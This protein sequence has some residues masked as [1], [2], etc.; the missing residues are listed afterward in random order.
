MKLTATIT[1]LALVGCAMTAVAQ[2]AAAATV[3]TSATY[4]LVSRYSGKAVQV[5]STADGE[6]VVQATRVDS[7]AQQWQFVDSGGGYYRLKSRLSGKVVDIAS[8]STA[9]G[10]NVVQWTDKNATN[11]Q[12]SLAD[13]DGGYVRFVNRNSGKALDLWERSTADGAR[14]SQYDDNG[15]TNQQWQLV[16]LAAATVGAPTDPN[17]RYFGRW[18]YSNPAAYVSEWAGAY[19]VVGFTGRTIKLRQRNAI[20]FY[21]SIDGGADV[22]YTNR[23]GTVDLTP[24]PL[25]SGNHTMRVS[26]RPIAG[27]YRGDAVFQ[28][29]QLDAGA[30]TFAPTVPSRIVEF[31]GDSITVGQL[32]SKQALTAYGWLASERLGLGHTQIAVGGACLVSAAD[33]C[34]GMSD[35]F[36]RTGLQANASNWDFSRY[37]ADVVVINLGTNDVGHSVTGA[38]FQT[39]YVTLLRRA[40]EKYPNATV[41]ALQTFRKRFIPE[42]QAA[43][44]TVNDPKIRFVDTTGW[45]VESTDTSDNVH[46]N[47]QGHRK[48]ADRLAPLISAALTS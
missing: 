33:G 38:Q 15:G 11:Q 35:R 32:S 34:I 13:S 37:R 27:S 23:S 22:S 1:A 28:G 21:V 39:A 18:N 17:I 41:L 48:I 36:L 14:I 4:V 46:P 45:I 40:R 30:T 42:T 43:V 9:N 26:Y 10:A 19:V 44:Q 16:R 25:A 3:D 8:S 47:D 6:A 2:P 12:F 7:T 24:T 20:D 31:V 5:G 29:V